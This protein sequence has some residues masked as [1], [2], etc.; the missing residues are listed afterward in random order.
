MLGSRHVA[1]AFE[2]LLEIYDEVVAFP[3]SWPTR[4]TRSWALSVG[5]VPAGKL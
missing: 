3:V 4:F 2:R 1:L 5:V